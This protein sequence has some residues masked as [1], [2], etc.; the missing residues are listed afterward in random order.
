M[1]VNHLKVLT[2]N[3]QTIAFCPYSQTVENDTGRAHL[4]QKA[5]N[6]KCVFFQWGFQNFGK[7][8]WKG[9]ILK[10]L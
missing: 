2:E 4:E 10:N 7:T 3:V 6:T 5:I 1:V 8:C 9:D